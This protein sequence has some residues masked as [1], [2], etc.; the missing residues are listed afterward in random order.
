VHRACLLWPPSPTSSAKA[1][2]IKG[3]SAFELVYAYFEIFAIVLSTKIVPL[4]FQKSAVQLRRAVDKLAGI[5]RRR[6][7]LARAL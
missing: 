6:Q 7:P 5:M 2:R 1:F 4:P 3:I